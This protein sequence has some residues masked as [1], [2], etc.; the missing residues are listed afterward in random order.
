MT[1]L[2]KPRKAHRYFK[3]FASVERRRQCQLCLRCYEEH[4]SLTHNTNI[5]KPMRAIPPRTSPG[6]M[7]GTTSSCTR[8]QSRPTDAV[9]DGGSSSKT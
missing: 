1:K 2:S 4:C 9:G 7:D 6:M 8:G 5:R 3:V